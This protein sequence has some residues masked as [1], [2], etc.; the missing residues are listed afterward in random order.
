M[1]TEPNNH[2][3]EKDVIEISHVIECEEIEARYRI[4]RPGDLDLIA[5]FGNGIRGLAVMNLVTRE[6]VPLCA[7]ILP[8]FTVM[9]RAGEKVIKA[10]DT[11]RIET[12]CRVHEES[13][14]L[15]FQVMSP[16]RGPWN[17]LLGEVG[18]SL[19]IFK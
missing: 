7:F 6:S 8:S 9:C 16:T 15:L 12:Y 10:F 5:A 19:Y 4:A 1:W 18:A 14:T 3:K 2:V 17:S 11:S 13:G